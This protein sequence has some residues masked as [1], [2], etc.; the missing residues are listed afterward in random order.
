MHETPESNQSRLK[1][2]IRA[3]LITD[4]AWYAATNEGIFISVDEGK[5]WY[6]DPVLG[7]RDLI[8]LDQTDNKTLAVVS[9]AGRGF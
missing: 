1:P 9:A 4:K 2:R 6:G 7:E 8:A 5:K 3:L